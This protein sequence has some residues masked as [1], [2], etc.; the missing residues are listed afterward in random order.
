VIGR[1][2]RRALPLGAGPSTE[3]GGGEGRRRG[4]ARN[5]HG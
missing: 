3:V 5:G 2:R 1:W 4:G